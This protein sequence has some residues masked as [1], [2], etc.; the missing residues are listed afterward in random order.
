MGCSQII[1]WVLIA[2]VPLL[3]GCGED[4]LTI[5][6]NTF[7]QQEIALFKANGTHAV[8]HIKYIPA[9][10]ITN[11]KAL[12]QQAQ[13]VDRF[14]AMPSTPLDVDPMYFGTQFAGKY[15]QFL[16]DYK[17]FI[18]KKSNEYQIELYQKQAETT[19]LEAKYNVE[20]TKLDEYEQK[21]GHLRQDLNNIAR[22]Y[23]MRRSELDRLRNEILAEFPTNSIG[24]IDIPVLS[25]FSCDDVQVDE[26]YRLVS[27][28]LDDH[29]FKCFGYQI[30]SSVVLTTDLKKIQST[31][32]AY[33]MAFSDTYG[34]IED[35]TSGQSFYDQLEAVQ[36]SLKVIDQELDDQY[37]TTYG[38]L[39]NKANKLKK[40]IEQSKLEA[41]AYKTELADKLKVAY[42]TDANLNKEY[43][44]LA[45]VFNSYYEQVIANTITPKEEQANRTTIT[46]DKSTVPENSY[47]FIQRVL[48]EPNN[49]LTSN[50]WVVAS[51]NLP[52]NSYKVTGEPLMTTTTSLDT[53]YALNRFVSDYITQM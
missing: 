10:S 23:H 17:I 7:N 38:E 6:T 35:K 41:Q 11:L 18:T 4:P 50:V 34:Y 46:I 27:S 15:K 16:N 45:R 5:D 33:F 48:V 49:Q 26:G 30:P 3:H 52:E 44:E 21:E 22:L 25:T 29:Y 40:Q 24:N 39:D 51:T 31:L 14:L 47:L 19:A 12:G 8:V 36:S 1:R 32:A 37:K 20:R 28:P 9:S 42:T 53:K 43:M 2:S 13:H